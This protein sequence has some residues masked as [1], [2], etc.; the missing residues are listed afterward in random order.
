MCFQMIYQQEYVEAP[1]AKTKLE[2]RDAGGPKPPIEELRSQVKVASRIWLANHVV[3][4]AVEIA[5]AHG[6]IQEVKC[7]ADVPEMWERGILFTATRVAQ[8]LVDVAHREVMWIDHH[9]QLRDKVIM[10]Q[11]KDFSYAAMA[12]YGEVRDDKE[13]MGDALI[14]REV[15]I[16]F[17]M[18]IEQAIIYQLP[19]GWQEV[20]IEKARTAR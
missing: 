9:I 14:R 8:C 15:R 10:L 7:P 20:E 12:S 13:P 3:L 6:R 2:V 5:T 17:G 18:D 11:L 16:K 19:E 4:K 1:D